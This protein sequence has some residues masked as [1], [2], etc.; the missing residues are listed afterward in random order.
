MKTLKN[1]FVARSCEKPFIIVS[2][3]QREGNTEVTAKR[4]TWGWQVFLKL[5]SSLVITYILENSLFCWYN[6]KLL[7]C[8]SISVKIIAKAYWLLYLL[9]SL[10]QAQV[11]AEGNPTK[12][13]SF[14]KFWP[15]FANRLSRC[16]TTYFLFHFQCSILTAKE[17]KM[18]LGRVVSLGQF[19]QPTTQMHWY[20]ELYRK[21]AVPSHEQNCTQLDKL[22]STYKLYALCWLPVR[23]V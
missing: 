4:S 23:S 17:V 7:F 9:H 21:A 19:H 14:I 16:K 13:S 8:L 5:S 15:F 10:I 3:W 12:L 20:T 18:R 22:S 1:E 2:K 11:S 6:N